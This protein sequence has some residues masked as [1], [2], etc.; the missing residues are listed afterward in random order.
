PRILFINRSYWPDTEATGQ[1]LTDLCEDLS[2]E[3]DITV[4]AG[5]PNH[6]QPGA[7]PPRPGYDRHGEVT[8]LRVMHTQFAKDSFVGRITNLLSFT[9]SAFLRT[10]F[11]DHPDVIVTETDPFFLPLL[12][13]W[14]KWRYQCRYVAYLQ[15]VYPDIA[16][17]VGKVPEGIITRILRS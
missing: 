13:R 4:V 10:Q 7:P 14:L 5:L 1:L 3:F 8:V 9:I 11:I 17:A 2:P 15:D 6:L 12:G 16:V